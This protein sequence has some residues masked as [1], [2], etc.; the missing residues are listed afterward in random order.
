ML[1]PLFMPANFRAEADDILEGTA[2]GGIMGAIVYVVAGAVSTLPGSFIAPAVVVPLSVISGAL[3]FAG[4]VIRN[5]RTKAA[6]AKAAP[7]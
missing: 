3:T 5:S 7:S 4:T 1:P 2:D 6:A